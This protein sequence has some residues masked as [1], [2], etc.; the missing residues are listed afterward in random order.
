MPHEHQDLKIRNTGL[1]EEDVQLLSSHTLKTGEKF[2][3][4]RYSSIKFSN[5]VGIVK[6]GNVVIEVLPKIDYFEEGVNFWRSVLIEML[7][8][9]GFIPKIIDDR[10]EI[11]SYS[12]SLLDI[13][14]LNYLKMVEDILERGL[15][16]SYVHKEENRNAVKGKILIGEHIKR[17]YSHKERAYCDHSVFTSNNFYNSIIKKTLSL[18]FTATTQPIISSKSRSI[19][20]HFDGINDVRISSE[21][22]FERMPDGRKYSYYQDVMNLSKLI[23]FGNSLTLNEG[24][25]NVFSMFFDMNILFEKYIGKMFKRV[26]GRRVKLQSGKYFWENKKIRPDIIIEGTNN[27]AIDTKWKI[28]GQGPIDA[29]LKQ[30]YVYSRY[31]DAERTILLYPHHTNFIERTGSFRDGSGSCSLMSINIFEKNGH[32]KKDFSDEI[33]AMISEN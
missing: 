4:V 22:I 20:L 10:V 21:K 23:L 9:S 12:S 30:M 24:R 29:D 17:N 32:L 13:L 2:F 15:I 16:K 18:I 8:I 27:I 5:Y 25:D 31:F 26:L 6:V 28:S 19:L 14:F 1:R 3:Q 11:S 7:Q 33:E